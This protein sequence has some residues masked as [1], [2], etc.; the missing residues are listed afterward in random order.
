MG[1]EGGGET[2]YHWRCSVLR[3]E[4]DMALTVRACHL[5]QLAV[6]ALF[7]HCRSQMQAIFT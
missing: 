7:P 2:V 4:C 6:I 1:E 3:Y 5:E